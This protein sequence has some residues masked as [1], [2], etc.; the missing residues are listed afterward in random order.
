MEE[1]EI[2]ASGSRVDIKFATYR[3]IGDISGNITKAREIEAHFGQEFGNMGDKISG[4]IVFI[5][6][7]KVY[8][9]YCLYGSPRLTRLVLV[10]E[11]HFPTPDDLELLE[12]LRKP[13]KPKE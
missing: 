11:P 1:I 13:L 6:K 8:E 3:K 9:I 5:W 12:M 7:K 4:E 2:V 10:G